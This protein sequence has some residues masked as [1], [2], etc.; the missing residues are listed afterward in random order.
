MGTGF[1]G[2]GT[3]GGKAE[4]AQAGSFDPYLAGILVSGRRRKEGKTTEKG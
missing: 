2:E 3:T 1:S 4:G